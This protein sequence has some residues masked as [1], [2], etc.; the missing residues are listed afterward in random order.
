MRTLP[1]VLAGLTT[2]VQTAAGQATRQGALGPQPGARLDVRVLATDVANYSVR[3]PDAW[4]WHTDTS[5]EH[6]DL[7]SGRVTPLGLKGFL[8]RASIVAVWEGAQ[9]ADLN[10][11]GD[12]LDY[13]AF[14]LDGPSTTNLGLAVATLMHSGRFAILQVSEAAQGAR[15]LDGDGDATGIVSQ[16]VD[17]RSGSIHDLGFEVDSA[18]YFF[19]ALDSR[20]FFARAE[21]ADT[22][23]LNGDGVLD[24]FVLYLFDA[25]SGLLQNLGVGMHPT[26]EGALS[27]RGLA[28][29]ADERREARDFNADGDMFDPVLRVV[30][31]DGRQVT[32]LPLAGGFYSLIGDGRSHPAWVGSLLAFDVCE[33]A[34]GV[35]LDGDGDRNGFVAHVIDLASGRITGLGLPSFVGYGN[36]A[37][38]PL[39]V[40]EADQRDLNGDGDQGDLL[41]YLGR[42]RDGAVLPTTR[43]VTFER[44][45]GHEVA[46]LDALTGHPILFDVRDGSELEIP[47]V[48][49]TE[50]QLSDGVMAYRVGRELRLYDARL[51]REF[52]THLEVRDFSGYLPG[53]PRGFLF[54]DPAGVLREARLY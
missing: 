41:L 35:D 16:L 17:L 10:G 52:P 34:Q 15:D 18:M 14:R 21:R 50:V 8:P 49:N 2:W 53:R 40:S 20:A 7:G 27:E 1:F 12:Q 25:D 36:E 28:V 19:Q 13:V 38:L 3:A 44:L 46:F 23:D 51:G 29:L 45:D 6:I 54:V 39:H 31:L 11:D 47:V 33:A 43:E 37:L 22:G 9:A 48:A 42:A 26:F 30:S 24:D 5:V 4:I 32:T